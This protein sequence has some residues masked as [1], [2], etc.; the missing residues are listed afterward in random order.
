MRTSVLLSILL[1]ACVSEAPDQ[2]DTANTEV[3]VDERS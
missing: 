2:T 1:A 3:I